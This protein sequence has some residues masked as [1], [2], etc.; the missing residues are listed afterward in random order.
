MKWAVKKPAA[1]LENLAMNLAQAGETSAALYV[2]MVREGAAF[3][4]KGT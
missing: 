3:Q 1:Q 4:R 2:C